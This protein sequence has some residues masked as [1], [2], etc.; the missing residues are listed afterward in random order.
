MGAE[1]QRRWWA[2]AAGVER[3]PAEAVALFKQAAKAGNVE[4]RFHLGVMHLHGEGV[5]QNVD[6]AQ[7]HLLEAATV[8]PRF[9]ACRWVHCPESSPVPPF[10]SGRAG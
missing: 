6:A 2:A 9:L 7:Q 5:P 4:A 3:D 10:L 8:C 1:R